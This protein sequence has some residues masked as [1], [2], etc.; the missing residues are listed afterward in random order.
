MTDVTELGDLVIVGQRRRPGGSFPPGSSGGGGGTGA[1][2]QNELG[3]AGPEEP[4]PH[5]CDNPDTALEWNADAAAA[6]ALR[7]MKRF[8]QL[9]HNEDSFANREYGT[10]L[11]QRADGAIIIG[12]IRHGD[13]MI[14]GNGN[15]TG[16][17]PNV[18][19]PP[20]GCGLGTTIL[21]MVHTHVSGSGAPSVA[22]I[23]WIPYINSVRGGDSRGRIYI[24]AFDGSAYRTYIYDHTNAQHAADTGNVGPEVNPDAQPC[25]GTEVI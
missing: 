6:E 13:P 23:S 11:C 3:E 5:P 17:L 18:N 19:I 16:N 1:P 2:N 25:L 7:R 22:D 10:L 8:A 14:D 24:T 20:D 12:E 9:V 15:A 4:Q 21:A